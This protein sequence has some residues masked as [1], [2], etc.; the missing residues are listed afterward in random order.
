METVL[1]IDDEL[2]MRRLCDD[3]LSLRGFRVLTAENAKE[4]LAKL[5]KGGIDIVLLDIMMPELSGLE[6]LPIIKKTDPDVFVIIITAY[7]TLESAIEALKK[8][9]YDYIR[10][11]FRPHELYHSVDKAISKRRIEL[12]NKRLIQDLQVKVKELGTL[13]RVGQYIHS[14][15]EI[16]RLLEKIVLSIAA[17]MGVEIVSIMLIDKETQEMVIKAA[18]G[19]PDEVVKTT[20][21][22]VGQGIAGWV[23]E[24]GEPLLIHDIEK[25]PR[26][27][28]LAS[29]AKY[30]TK[31]LLSVPLFTKSG[32]IGVLNVNCKATGETFNEHDLELLTTFSSQ[33]A[34]AIEN[35]EL[36]ARVK[37]FSLELEKKV[38]IATAELAHS[39]QELEAKVAELSTLY[40][41]SR[42]MASTL[43][44]REVSSRM[45][46]EVARIIPYD[47]GEI[48]VYDEEARELR[49]LATA[50][51]G[52][53][54]AREGVYPLDEG[55][56]PG[57]LALRK[58][59][60]LLPHIKD[61]NRSLL[62]GR[63]WGDGR[64][65]GSFLAVP[66]IKGNKLIGTFE[67]ASYKTGIFYEEHLTTLKALGSHLATSIENAK[68]YEDIQKNF[69]ETLRSLV[70]SLEA[71]DEYTRD[72]SERVTRLAVSVAKH[73]GLSEEQVQNI[74]IAGALHDIGKIGMDDEILKSKEKLTPP[75]L[76]AMREHPAVGARIL[77]PIKFLKGIKEIV[78]QHQERYD[79]TGYPQGLA[80]DEIAIEARI[81]AAA[82]AYDAMISR[83][84]YRTKV[85]NHREVLEE[86][87][88]CAGTQ[89][90]PNVVEA[91]IDLDR[92]RVRPLAEEDVT[93]VHC[94]KC[95]AG[96]KVRPS[97]IPAA[98]ARTKCSK[99]QEVFTIP[100]GR[101]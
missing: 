28:K 20:R 59:A 99:C 21:Q 95:K 76:Q 22:K 6:F 33:A 65:I 11:P 17:V 77:E 72:H 91:L 49:I 97:Q 38:R 90:D 14:L 54:E 78:L 27:A 48:C 1:V 41:A 16:D 57:W 13:N 40:E 94:P 98:G 30:K 43:D 55:R 5:E 79:G 56:Y 73:I 7:A 88:R 89:F 93:V 68:L 2:F 64:E 35:A 3:M 29:D 44:T 23:A 86:L 63:P 87:Q 15:V 61:E 19:L 60:I 85:F 80:G 70:T 47:V 24:K 92:K 83:R 18:T 46:E 36:Y 39:N 75:Q 71:R 81:L 74:R 32:V 26:F 37:D 31:S 52:S 4:G 10:K 100:G 8:G 58:E 45:L 51:G 53:T 96:Y 84:H 34:A 12:E 42:V 9:A 66:L 82:D 25:D 50:Q 67:L 62:K 101:A 69:L